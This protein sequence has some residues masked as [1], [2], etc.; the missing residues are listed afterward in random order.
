MAWQREIP[1]RME[2]G[3]VNSGHPRG[4]IRHE[5]Y[6]LEEDAMYFAWGIR[7]QVSHGVDY[8]GVHP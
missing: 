7:G 2:E 5:V 3:A 8:R 6:A 1:S 4:S